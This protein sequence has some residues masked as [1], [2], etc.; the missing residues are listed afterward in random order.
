MDELPFPLTPEAIAQTSPEVLASFFLQLLSRLEAAE[1]RAEAAEKRAEAAEK[2][3]KQLEERL[4]LTS[5]NSHKP[6][7]SDPP[8][9]P[10]K[11]N[12]KSKRKRGGQPGHKGHKREL[13]PPEKV[14]SIIEVKPQACRGCGHGLT[15]YESSQPERHQVTE[16]PPIKP[17]VTEYRRHHINCPLCQTRN[18][19]KLPPGVPEGQF[20]PRLLSMTALCSGAYDL[21]KRQIVSMFRDFFS[22]RMAVGTVVRNERVVSRALAHPVEE[23]AQYIKT[24]EVVNAD[25]T[26][27]KQENKRGWLWVFTTAMVTYFVLSLSREK[28]VPQQVLGKEFSGVIYS[29]RWRAY[30]WIP[31]EQRHFCW[32]HLIRDFKKIELRGG[33]DERLACALLDCSSRLFGSLKRVRAGTSSRKN[34]EKKVKEVK[35]KMRW[36]LSDGVRCIETKKVAR[37]C[38]CE[39]RGE[40][41][42]SQKTARFCKTLLSQWESLWVGA[43]YLE[44]TNNAAER[45]LRPAVVYR[46]KSFGV[47]SRAGAVFLE[48]IMTAKM[49]L[50]QQK[51]GVL[52]FLIE[53]VK[54]HLSGQLHP[55]LL[56]Q[57]TPTSTDTP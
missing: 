45:A 39:E 47:K 8:S 17:I 3:V 20:G 15:S 29:D 22:V 25:E 18:H 30:D 14:D 21:T 56:P 50:R 1:K 2:R 34:F 5:Q 10:K 52:E 31:P 48:R 16:L 28:K 41:C 32:A 12:K 11:P 51:R 6:P 54:S 19:A 40:S 33:R 23:V 44:L 38:A 13:L 4:A 42:L 24:S 9:T 46:K 27:M 53:A 36:W 26:G 55:S 37:S 49:S 7:S 35:S 43:K 57:T